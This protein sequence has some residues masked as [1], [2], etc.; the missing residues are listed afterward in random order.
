MNQE[1]LPPENPIAPERIL[2]LKAMGIFLE[3][4]YNNPS[5]PT[6]QASVIAKRCKL[7]GLDPVVLGRNLLSF[8]D[9]I[10]QIQ[11]RGDFAHADK[12]IHPVKKTSLT[13]IIKSDFDY[14]HELMSLNGSQLEELCISSGRKPISPEKEIELVKKVRRFM[15]L[16]EANRDYMKDDQ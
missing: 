7:R 2:G 11:K 4:S 13:S 12:S 6:G 8:P 16:N 10:S 14:A 1:H 15:E 9:L 5:S 3:A